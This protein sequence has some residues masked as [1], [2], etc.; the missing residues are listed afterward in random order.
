MTRPG[1][2][3]EVIKYKQFLIEKF[4]VTCTRTKHTR[5]RAYLNGQQC[6]QGLN[7]QQLKLVLS[8]WPVSFNGP[9]DI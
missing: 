7:L 3:V 6:G 8:T 2:L 5:Y 1:Q 4:Y 9:W